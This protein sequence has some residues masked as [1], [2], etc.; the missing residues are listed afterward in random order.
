MKEFK[1]TPGPWKWQKSSH[2]YGYYFLANENETKSKN[3]II[4]DGSACG[5]YSPAIDVHGAD[6]Q[7]IAAAPELLEALQEFVD[8]FPDVI[9]GDAIMPALDMAEAAINKALGVK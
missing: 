1:G 5:E 7:L 4:D 6:A 8:L 9:D 2:T 3:C